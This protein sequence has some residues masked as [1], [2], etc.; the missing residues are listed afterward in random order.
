MAGS[1]ISGRISDYHLRTY[2]KQHPDN[3]AH[4]ERRLHLQFPGIVVALFG[5]LM[6]G[7]LSHFHIHVSSVIIASSIAAFGMTWVF[8]TTTAYLTES[9]KT[10]PAT[11]VA[12]AGL[13]RNP[14]AAVAAAVVEPLIGKMGIGWC[15][16]GLAFVELACVASSLWLM[17]MGKEMRRRLEERQLTAGGSPGAG[18]GGRLGEPLGGP[19]GGPAP[20]KSLG[21]EKTGINGAF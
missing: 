2:N 11:L 16:S 3:P 20:E 21:G 4:P 6:F 5:V 9:T 10:S 8:I 14:A 17:V 1:V 13:F 7:W 12:L 18:P 19:L 15:F